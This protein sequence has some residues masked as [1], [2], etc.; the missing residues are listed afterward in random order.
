MH[1][2]GDKVKLG[3]MRRFKVLMGGLRESRYKVDCWD[4]VL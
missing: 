3:N 4:V 1:D 2:L